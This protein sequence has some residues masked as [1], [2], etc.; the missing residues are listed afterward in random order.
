MAVLR[1]ILIEIKDIFKFSAR[2]DL[3]QLP[4]YLRAFKASSKDECEKALKEVEK[5]KFKC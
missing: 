3:L 4:Q 1:G 5:L 2:G